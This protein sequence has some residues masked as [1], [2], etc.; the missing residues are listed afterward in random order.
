M[1]TGGKYKTENPDSDDEEV[2]I[3]RDERGFNVILHLI[4]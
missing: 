2:V 3:E 1:F 4:E